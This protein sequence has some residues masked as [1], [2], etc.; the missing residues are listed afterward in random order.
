M[1][2]LISI[3]VIF[4]IIISSFVGCSGADNK[5]YIGEGK[6]TVIRSL[7]TT[8]GFL[9]NSVIGSGHLP[10]NESEMIIR[11]S[12]TLAPVESD[13][14]ST[15]SDLEKLVDSTYPK[16][17]AQKLLNEPKKYYDIDGKLYFD[18]QYS[19]SENP[20]YDW[21]DFTVEFKKLNDDGNYL[22]KVSLKKTNGFPVSV[23]IGVTDKDGVIRLC[24]FYE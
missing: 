19:E 24:D 12:K 21:S 22:F 4:I 8:N 10:V 16:E 17:V 2:R 3:A 9:A 1:K 20:K 6:M 13:I 18:M 15:Y 23:K 14:I 11:D 5:I 7:V